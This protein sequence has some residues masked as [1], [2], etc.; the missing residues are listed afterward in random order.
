MPEA[1][2]TTKRK[3]HKILDSLSN[4]S[5]TSVPLTPSSSES[6]STN[7]PALSA[8]ERLEA[9]SERARKRIRSSGSGVSLATFSTNNASTT[10][11]PRKVPIAG[12]A[13]SKDK[14]KTNT[15]PNFAP[16]SQD[17]FLVRLKTFSNV[18]L[19]HP[20]PSALSEVHWAKRG[21]ICSG[22]NTVSCKG[23][24]E[25]R[26]VVNT[27]AVRRHAVHDDEAD[28]FHDKEE[29]E[30]EAA[31]E[32]AL[33][34]RY[35]DEIVKGHAESCLWRKAGCKDDIYRLSLVRPG[36][37]QPDLRKRYRS[38]VGN[39]SSII[40]VTTQSVPRDKDAD[41]RK[42]LSVENL[43]EDLPS[44]ILAADSSDTGL[45]A[46]ALDIAL[47]GWQG[48]SSSGNDL[49]SCESC[50]QRIGLWMYQPGYDASKA[51]AESED[52]EDEGSVSTINLVEMHRE[53]CPWRN[54][55]SQHATGSLAGLN[56]CQILRQVVSS[57]A[58]E[59]RRRSEEQQR[60][61][62]SESEQQDG[63][64][65]VDD[66]VSVAPSLSRQEIERQDKERE[67]KLKKLK[68]M[69]SV[70]RRSGK[71]AAQKVL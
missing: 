16:W 17:A 38:L 62:R 25:R 53:H 39:S 19:W 71:S 55:A 1:I 44:D 46:K 8:R 49:L 48:S 36:I 5:S 63:S 27:E 52:G 14:T 33:V 54:A 50:F 26:V 47:H 32:N 18:S 68:A 30:D 37:W 20:K 31:F 43:F 66:T 6:A 35:K 61:E 10:S 28:E 42:L 11:L 65:G 45:N 22:V 13:P 34:A 56:G 15:L 70:K 41:E 23:G 64:D 60:A 7:T 51:S 24:C 29:E 9:A 21:W 4:T 12:A 59:Q 2:A 40:D 58:R 57:Y 3:F 67:S 69:F